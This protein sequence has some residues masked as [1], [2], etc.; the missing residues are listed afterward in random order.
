MAPRG[1]IYIGTILLEINRWAKPEKRPSYRVSEWLDRFAAAGFDGTELWQYHATLAAPEELARLASPRCP[2]AVFSSY[3]A[4]TDAGRGERRA[5]TAVVGRLGCR[6]VKFNLGADPG[7]WAAGLAAVREWRAELPAGARLLCECHPG[8]VVEEPAQARRFF[9]ELGADGWEII[10]HPFSRREGL[11]EW[12][13][14]FGPAVTHAHLQMREG[15]RLVRFDRRPELAAEAVE[16]LRRNAFAGSYTLEFTEG[17][18][19]PG[20]SIEELFANA[21]LDLRFLKDL[22]K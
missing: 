13:D 20:E 15:E 10:V 14:L 8:T 5:C 7:A 1:K 2:P 21:L 6:G 3:C 17:T 9:D 12:F 11:Q 18:A 22:L 4:M 19:T 16:V